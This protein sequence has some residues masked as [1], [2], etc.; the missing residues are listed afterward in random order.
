MHVRRFLREQGF[1]G[2]GDIC[3]MEKDITELATQFA[4]VLSLTHINLRMEIVRDDACRKFHRDAVRA[5]LICTYAGPGTEYAFR[6]DDDE[7]ARFGSVPTGCPIVLKGKSWPGVSPSLVTHRSPPIE[8]LSSLRL[9]VVI[10]E[11]RSV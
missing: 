10:D 1:T 4:E 6:C 2:E 11:A 8:G 7:A 5:R 3:W 9:V